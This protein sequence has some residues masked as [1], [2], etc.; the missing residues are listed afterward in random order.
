MC[1]DA[2]WLVDWLVTAH[3]MIKEYGF[4]MTWIFAKIKIEITIKLTAKKIRNW[5]MYIQIKKNS[6]IIIL[7]LLVCSRKGQITNYFSINVN[8]YRIIH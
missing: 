2:D 1:D 8:A 6:I 7:L 5:I 4:P 3:K